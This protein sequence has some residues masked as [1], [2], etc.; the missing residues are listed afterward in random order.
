MGAVRHAMAIASTSMAHGLKLGAS[1]LLALSLGGCADWL[2]VVKNPP[3]PPSPA[4]TPAVAVAPPPAPPP[5]PPSPPPAA[6]VVARLPPA[7]EPRSPAGGGF[8]RII[9]LDQPHLVA[10]MGEP[11]QQAESAPALI[12]RYVGQQCELDVYFYLDLQSKAMR[13]LHYEVRSHESAEP[14]T[15]RCYDDLVSERRAG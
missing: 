9:G 5:K 14:T 11:R 6:P 7:Q 8:E 13:A 3:P 15:Q 2:D 1:I 12:W 10:L 4:P